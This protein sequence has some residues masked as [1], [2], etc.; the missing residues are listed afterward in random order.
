MKTLYEHAGSEAGLHRFVG[1]FYARVLADPLLKP[2]FGAGKPEH[3]A[4]LTAFTA[5]CFGGPDDFST[6]IPDAL[7]VLFSGMVGYPKK[8]MHDPSIKDWIAN[9]QLTAD[10]WYVASPN[11]SVPET[12]RLERVGVAVEEFLDKI[13]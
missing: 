10:A 12:R 2:L 6:K 8:G 4:H 11:L 13:A 1:T 5:E 3:V 7:D 9:H